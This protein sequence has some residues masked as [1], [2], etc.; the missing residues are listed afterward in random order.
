MKHLVRL[1]VGGAAMGAI[2]GAMV[3]I[4][5]LPGLLVAILVVEVLAVAYVGGMLLLAI[6]GWER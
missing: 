1:G 5:T 6:L 4:G 2:F 3:L